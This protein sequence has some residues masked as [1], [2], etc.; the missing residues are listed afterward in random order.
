MN[1]LFKRVSL[2]RRNT[3]IVGFAKWNL[4]RNDTIYLL[5]ICRTVQPACNYGWQIIE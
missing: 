4:G 1:D 2:T 3:V 5:A